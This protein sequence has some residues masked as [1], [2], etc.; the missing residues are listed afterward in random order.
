MKLT[1]INSA[2][3]GADKCRE[4]GIR[5]LVLFADLNQEDFN[6]IHSPIDDY[7]LDASETLYQESSQP[8]FIYTIRSGLV[9]L[10]HYLP[11]G[12]YRI[13]RLLKQGDVG[14]MEA[15]N[16]TPYLHHA[17]TLENTSI[18]RI[19]T[20]EIEYLNQKS[21]RLFKQLTARWQKVISDADIWLAS[22]TVGSAKKR[23]ASL[24]LYLATSN[25]TE[26]DCSFL[27]GREDM[28]ALLGITTETASRVTAEFKREGLIKEDHHHVCIDSK[29]LEEIISATA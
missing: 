24:L 14:G 4:C 23:V 17:I 29:K 6:L 7:E 11:N 1:R 3:D 26:G 25:D 15:L 13:V 12:N 16:G 27:L 20:A 9:K 22:L 5:H 18:C 21:P 28:G 19:P 10:V 8:Q 2:W